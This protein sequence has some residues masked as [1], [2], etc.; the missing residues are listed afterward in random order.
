MHWNETELD[1]T[2][3]QGQTDRVETIVEAL[4]IVSTLSALAPASRVMMRRFPAA[5]ASY[6]CRKL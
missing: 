3:W 5:R 6:G 2:H 1:N 4:H